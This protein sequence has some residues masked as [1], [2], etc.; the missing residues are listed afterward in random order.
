MLLRFENYYIVPIQIKDA[1]PIYDFVIDNEDRLKRYFP[2][3]LKKNLTPEL[4]KIFVKKKVR[5]FQKNKEFLFTINENNI[6]ELLGL[7]YLKA[8]DW[9]NKHGELAYCIGHQ[10]EGKGITTK[11]ITVLTNYIFSKFDLRTLK[12]I[13]HKTNLPSILVAKNCHFTWIKTL[14]NEHTPPGEKPLDMEL[15]ELYKTIQH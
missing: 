12:I 11:A 10:F 7:I 9:K 15:Y 5:K 1:Y 2:L 3:T 8:L 13:V 14:K 6:K 4:S